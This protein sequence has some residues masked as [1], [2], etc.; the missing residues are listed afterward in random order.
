MTKKHFE[1][2]AAILAA[3]K[4]TNTNSA[5][6]EMWEEITGQL[7]QFFKGQNGNFDYIKFFAACNGIKR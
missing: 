7:A 2:V 5:Q 1:A 6:H 3:T 4:P